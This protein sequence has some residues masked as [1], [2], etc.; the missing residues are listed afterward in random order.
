MPRGKEID[1]LI[2]KALAGKPPR[3]LYRTLFNLAE[4]YNQSAEI[5]ITQIKVKNNADYAAPAIMSRSFSV[6]LLLKFFIV[7]SNLDMLKK[8]M[9]E[10][11]NRMLRG[12]KYTELH[13]KISDR[14]KKS[15]AETYSQRTGNSIGAQDF[16]A[17]LVEIGND[18]FV[19]WR[20]VY[21][22]SEHKYIDM[23][24]LALIVDSLGVTAQ[25]TVR[26]IDAKF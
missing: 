11:L 17:L 16:R 15:I 26:E 3:P 4:C 21:E 20:Y 9:P 22:S 25:A 13:D 5:T 24:L 12:H 18:P 23:K 1:A 8:P 6:E 2:K 19:G 7:A 14:F 10:K